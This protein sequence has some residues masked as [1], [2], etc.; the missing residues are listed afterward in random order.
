MGNQAGNFNINVL[1]WLGGIIDSDGSIGI[2]KNI[3][4]NNKFVYAPN[5]VVTNSNAIIIEQCHSVLLDND[6][7]HH[8]KK[9]G[10]CSNIVIGRPGIIIK[11]YNLMKGFILTKHNE[12][13]L[14]Y[15]F[16]N[17]R[18]KSVNNCGCNWKANYSD[19]EHAIY[20]KLKLLNKNHYGECL[21]Y[22]I[23]ESFIDEYVLTKYTNSWLSGFIDGDG[24]ITINKIKRPSGKYQYQPMVHIVTGSPI[25]KQIISFYLDRYNINY[26]LKKGLPGVN[27]RPNC[28]YKKFEFYIRSFDDCMNV[29]KM[30]TDNLYGKKNRA[31][32]LDSFCKS[33]KTNR[34]KPYS[35]YEINLFHKIKKDIK[36]TSTTISKTLNSEDIV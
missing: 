4:K 31:L 26:Y 11:F 27:H 2:S 34:N 3:R 6:I 10:T 16:C 35:D 28:R 1:R 12:L 8:I 18:V 20:E 9:N 32:H 17:S 29:L 24:C 22:G 23:T 30:I 19:Y 15:D 21:E 14:I 5:I 33:R 13:N 36:D 25:S 7:N